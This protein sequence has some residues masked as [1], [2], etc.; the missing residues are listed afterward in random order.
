M[1]ERS[2]PTGRLFRAASAL[3]KP[4]S[5]MRKAVSFALVGLV[6][7][8]VDASVFFLVYAWLTGAARTV[9]FLASAADL[10][11]CG[12]GEDLA[13]VAANVT[14]WLV[15]MSFSYVMN[16]TITFAAE[17][18]RKLKFSAYLAFAASGVLGVIANT[19]TLVLVAQFFPV[20]FAKACAILVSFVVNFS[21]SHFVVF[22]TRRPD[23]SR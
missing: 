7:T 23:A 21:M 6:N 8:A 17:S 1:T 4:P 19:A 14:A 16:S 9:A 3:R 10:C 2:Q 22:R 18:G 20:W 11:R 5:V 15:A 13:L 12:A